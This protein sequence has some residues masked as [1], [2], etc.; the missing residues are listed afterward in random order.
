MIDDMSTQRYSSLYC[1]PPG[2]RY[3]LIEDD[4]ERGFTPELAR[5]VDAVI[6][7]AGITEPV[8]SMA[9]PSQV[10]DNN[11]RITRHVSDVCEAAGTP[12]V[13]VSTTSVY[14]SRD[15]I[16]D[17]HSRA[18]NPKTP[19]AQCKLAEEKYVLR[20]GGNNQ[21]VVFRLGSI[22]GVSPGMRFHTAVNRFCWQAS[23]GAP[24]EVW[25]TAL[26]Q[27]RPYLAVEDAATL[28]ADAVLR[29]VYPDGIVN[30]VTCNAT[31]RD[32][33]NAIQ[34]AGY[35]VQVEMV[36]STVMND[37]SFEISVAKALSLGFSFT[38]DLNAGVGATLRLLEG[39]AR[40]S[41]P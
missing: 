31:V 24:I 9:N 5:R 19:Y 12:L 15:P 7:L 34:A 16:A 38:G 33:L 21:R 10:Y 23:R 25:S 2:P 26:E 37:L 13:F 22:F 8:A 3:S 35:I 11:L 29:N 41:D 40:T 32:I 39:L 30:A 6:H 20:S 4:A 14:T 28:L 27:V 17:E 18:L 36:E 1:L